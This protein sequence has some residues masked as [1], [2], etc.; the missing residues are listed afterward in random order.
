[1]TTNSP[2]NGIRVVELT[3]SPTNIRTVVGNVVDDIDD[4]MIPVFATTAAR[5]LAITAPAE[6]MACYIQPNVAGGR[7]LQ[8][9]TN[10]QWQPVFA[11]G[12]YRFK[13]ATTS[14]VKAAVPNSIADPDLVFPMISNA[15]YHFYIQL[16]LSGSDAGDFQY[17]MNAPTGSTLSYSHLAPTGSQSAVF[18]AGDADWATK[19]AVL[20]FP[21]GDIQIGLISGSFLIPCTIQGLI[22]T[23][24]TS[25]N[26]SLEWTQFVN[27]A[28]GTEVR[29][30][31]FGYL[32]R[33]S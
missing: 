13:A 16:F 12:P 7:T 5:D 19:C 31:S 11:A 2:I 24:A 10:S 28:T 25:G 21:A 33:V 6:G 32:T 9:Y 14:R 26:L 27:N 15:S 8:I 29:G 18:G 30:Q 4:R 3:D 20:A 22:T 23:G 17:R 1:M